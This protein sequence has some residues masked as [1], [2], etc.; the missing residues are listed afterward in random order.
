MY[1]LESCG[2]FQ[3]KEWMRAVDK[4]KNKQWVLNYFLYWLLAFFFTLDDLYYKI[5]F[6]LWP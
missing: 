2:D 5:L 4:T 3:V 1:T 6:L